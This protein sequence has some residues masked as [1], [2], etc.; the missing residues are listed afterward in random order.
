MHPSIHPFSNHPSILLH[1]QLSSYPSTHFS[2]PLV[3][4]PSFR[5]SLHPSIYQPV[6]PLFPALL[7]PI[8]PVYPTLLPP[9]HPSYPPVSPTLLP[10]IHLCIHRSIASDHPNRWRF[11]FAPI[12]LDVSGSEKINTRG[13]RGH[14]GVATAA[15]RH[16][17][18]L[19]RAIRVSDRFIRAGGIRSTRPDTDYCGLELQP[20]SA[21]F[22]SSSPHERKWLEQKRRTILGATC[23]GV[24]DKPHWV[25]SRGVSRLTRM[26]RVLESS[27]NAWPLY[28][29]L[30]PKK[31]MIAVIIIFIMAII[32]N[33]N[34][35]ST[36]ITNS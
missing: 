26:L 27:I 25:V 13:F 18:G 7:P 8:Q 15:I 12:L 28:R 2:T 32:V 10:S 29:V 34:I 11:C 3:N 31:Y 30:A 17:G 9:V 23:L 21:I 5:P 19:S 4:P 16:R 22:F 6:S 14:A 35:N 24:R 36:L 33:M 20:I 1:I